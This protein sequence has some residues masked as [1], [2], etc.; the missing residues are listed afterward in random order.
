MPDSIIPPWVFEAH[1]PQC[2][3]KL[4]LKRES[5]EG[6]VQL[7]GHERLFCPVHGDQMSLE[8]ARRIAFKDS[9]D[10]IIDKARDFARDSLRDAFKDK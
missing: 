10:D 2:S 7:E 3:E 6:V 8:E 5:K 1:C 4:G 9:R